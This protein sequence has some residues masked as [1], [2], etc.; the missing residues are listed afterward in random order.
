MFDPL[1]VRPLKGFYLSEAAHGTQLPQVD[2]G[3]IARAEFGF[4]VATVLP[5]GRM[6]NDS[7]AHHIQVHID[8]AAF[9]EC[10]KWGRFA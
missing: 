3:V 1:A 9:I 10:L 4:A 6:L 5:L 8:E 2:Q 7:S